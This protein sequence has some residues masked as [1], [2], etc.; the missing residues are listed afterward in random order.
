MKGTYQNLNFK[1]DKDYKLG[2]CACSHQQSHY[3]GGWGFL[4]IQGQPEY[5]NDLGS[6][7]SKKLKTNFF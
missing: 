3:W 2:V 7:I 5:K 1:K 4:T 6:T